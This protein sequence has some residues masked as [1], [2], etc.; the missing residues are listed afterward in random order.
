LEFECW[1]EGGPE[2]KPVVSKLRFLDDHRDGG[3]P[4]LLELN[5][6][7]LDEET[8]DLWYTY[9][10]ERGVNEKLT[11]NYLMLLDDYD[12]MYYREFS[13]SVKKFLSSE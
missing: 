11:E 5:F 8:Q 3:D 6:A 12:E 2:A 9:L 4:R 10:E 13:A 1:L 7:D